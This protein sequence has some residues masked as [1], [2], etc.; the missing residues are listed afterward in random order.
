MSGKTDAA[1]AALRTVEHLHP[2]HVEPIIRALDAAGLLD[3]APKGVVH[4]AADDTALPKQP[5]LTPQDR[6]C[7]SRE[8]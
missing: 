5:L 4:A 3:G 8:E 7:D 2:V 1:R 6:R